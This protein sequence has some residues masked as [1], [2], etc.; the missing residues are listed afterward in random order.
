MTT[1]LAQEGQPPRGVSFMHPTICSSPLQG[2]ARARHWAD[3]THS[4]AAAAN[5]TGGQVLSLW[6]ARLQ[7]RSLLLNN[8]TRRGVINKG[9][10]GEKRREA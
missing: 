3:N 1:P 5:K 6:K 7:C 10:T 4:R 9:A 2:V 8:R